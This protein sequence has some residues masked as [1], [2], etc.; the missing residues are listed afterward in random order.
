MTATRSVAARAALG[1]VLLGIAALVVESGVRMREFAPDAPRILIPAS[2]GGEPLTAPQLRAR[3]ARDPVDYGSLLGLARALE[4]E[5]RKAEAA[6]AGREALALAPADRALLVQA[7]E[8]LARVGSESESLAVLRRLADLYPDTGKALWPAFVAALDTPGYRD[9]FADIARA[10]PRWWPDFFEF[11]CA[12]ATLEPLRAVYLARAAA[13]AATP[14]EQRCV[15]A[16][17]EREK[18][19]AD[20]YRL[21]LAT[22]PEDERSRAGGIFNGDFERPLSGIGFD[23]IAPGQ[24]AVAVDTA[25]ARGATGLQALRVRFADKRWAS[26]PIY[27]YLRLA[28]G[29]YRFDGRGRA[30]ALDTWLGVQ[31]G[32]YCVDALG[33]D[34]RQLAHTDAFAGRSDW[35]EF[36]VELAV[37]RECP[38]QL[39][40]L[41]LA[42]AD[43]SARTG[44]SGAV[45]LNGGLWFDD[46]RVA[47]LE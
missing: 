23:W 4:R 37:P 35:R 9:F 10:D 39:L 44:G 2:G 5:G 12:N 8:L 34:V 33:H 6:A 24:P 14:V 17:L 26:W 28:P 13:S 32:L 29:R 22:L 7:A 45:R 43:P 36:Q 19:W 40:R 15:I 3:V 47:A 27:Q 20:A 31:W 16:R 41:E 25:P 38:L 30:D 21:W 18:D 11:A 1:V 46:L 42:N